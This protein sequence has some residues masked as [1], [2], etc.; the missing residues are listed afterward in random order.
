M[1]DSAFSLHWNE[2]YDPIINAS[3]EATNEA[4]KLAGPDVLLSDL[5]ARIEEI[6]TSYE[7]KGKPIQPV[8]N[9]SGHMVDRYTIHSGKSIPLH[10]G[11]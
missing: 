8:R 11:N 10:G 1:V 7:Y 9:L 2:E 4:I 3:K 5:G 6:I